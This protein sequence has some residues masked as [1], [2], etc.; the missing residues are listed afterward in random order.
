MAL[1]VKALCVSDTK[2]LVLLQKESTMMLQ[3][4]GALS[5]SSQKVLTSVTVS[6]RVSVELLGGGRA[7]A[8]KRGIL[9]S[10]FSFFFPQTCFTIMY[11][12]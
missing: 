8:V 6:I 4:T 11:A 5:S 2:K 3:S 7:K 1:V 10:F 9:P 12:I